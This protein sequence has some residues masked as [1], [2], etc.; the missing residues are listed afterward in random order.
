[1]ILSNF[2]IIIVILV[3]VQSILALW[4]KSSLTNSI[5]HEYDKKLEDF[6]RDQL[7]KDKAAVV[8]EFLAEW[9]HLQGGDTKRLNQL[10]WE[11]SLYLPSEL[12]KD[13]QSMVTNDCNRKSAAQ[14]LIAVRNHLLDNEDQLEEFHISHFKHQDNYSM[15]SNHSGDNLSNASAR[16]K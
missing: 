5:K 1:M 14:I 11:L 13:I 8:A 4:L 16:K 12:V 2:Q 9:T 15:Q 3:A 10:L 7:R 6:K